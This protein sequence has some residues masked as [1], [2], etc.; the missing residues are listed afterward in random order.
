VADAPDAAASLAEV[1]ALVERR[2]AYL[3]RPQLLRAE[4][5][6]RARGGQISDAV[7]ALRESAEAARRQGALPRLG[8]TLAALR[9][10][11]TAAGD[12]ALASEAEA[13]LAGVV[14]RVGPEARALTWATSP[15]DPVHSRCLG[16]GLADAPEPP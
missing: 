11:A 9:T 14:A 7:A 10:V 3:T 16:D 5:L 8:R 13:E 1:T 12:T 15:S 2:E 4:G 6:L